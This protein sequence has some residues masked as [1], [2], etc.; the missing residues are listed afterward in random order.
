MTQAL[1]DGLPVDIISIAAAD[2][3]NYEWQSN[4]NAF[5]GLVI[6]GVDTYSVAPY[7]TTTISLSLTVVQNAPIPAN[8][9]TAPIFLP[10]DAF[11]AVINEAVHVALLKMGGQEFTESIALHQGFID[12]CMKTNSRLLE[13]G[14]FPTDYASVVPLQETQDPRFTL[15]GGK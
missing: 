14:I 15:Q 6:G 1:V 10:R 3:F 4:P 7:P 13:A 11:D 5:P 12:Y 9:P 2:R 8:T